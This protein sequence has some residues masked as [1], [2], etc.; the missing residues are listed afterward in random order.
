M[1][2]INWHRHCFGLC[3]AIVSDWVSVVPHT[4]VILQ[5]KQKNLLFMINSWLG[6]CVKVAVLYVGQVF[7]GGR[8]S[9]KS[10]D[11]GNDS[12]IKT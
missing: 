6:F 5:K 1:F 9:L 10:F 4:A 8:Q 7:S 2:Y 11:T 12:C 3:V